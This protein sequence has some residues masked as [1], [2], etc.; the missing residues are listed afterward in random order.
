MLY[1]KYIQLSIYVQFIITIVVPNLFK[2][3]TNFSSFTQPFIS[4]YDHRNVIIKF[5][6]KKIRI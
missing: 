6:I 4:Y 3:I 2:K 5:F 1:C